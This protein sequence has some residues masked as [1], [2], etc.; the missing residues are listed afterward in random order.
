MIKNPSTK[1]NLWGIGVLFLILLSCQ[2]KSAVLLPQKEIESV[3]IRDHYLVLILLDGSRP[4]EIEAGVAAG[5]LPTFK[6]LFFEEGARFKNVITAFPTVSSPCHQAFISGL[7]PGHHGVPS[8]DWYSRSQ[9]LYTDYLQPHHLRYTNTLF[10]NFRQFLE[11]KIYTDEP[12]LIFRALKGHPSLAVFE[13]ANFGAKYYFPRSIPA[14]PA[15]HSFVAKNHEHWDFAS[16]KYALNLIKKLPTQDLPRFSMINFYGMDFTTHF[17]RAHSTRVADLYIYYDRFLKELYKNFEERGLIKKT[18]F[19][20]ISDHGQHDLEA[21]VDLPKMLRRVGFDTG[22]LDK[23]NSQVV[24]GNHATGTTN[25]YFKT[26][27]DWRQRPS[28]A[29]LKNFPL[30]NKPVDLIKSFLKEPDIEAV[31]TPEGPW[32]T[33]LHFK[34]GHAIIKRRW[35]NNQFLYAYEPD[36]DTDPLDY[37]KNPVIRSWVEKKQFMD[38][39]AWLEQT[40]DK[41]MPD[42][43]VAVPQIF[44]DYRA[45]DMFLI[46]VKEKQFKTDKPSGHG[47]LYKE[48]LRVNFMLHGPDIQAGLY[49]YAR[50]VDAY[51]TFLA[52][53]GL[54]SSHSIDGIL[55]KEVFKSEF[56]NSTKLHQE[57]VGTETGLAMEEFENLLKQKIHQSELEDVE[58]YK[59]EQLLYTLEEFKKDR[60]QYAMP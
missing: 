39:E 29:E 57:R 10:F 41:D 9:D 25:L 38:A 45:G 40:H 13:P 2:Y 11:N 50:S 12:Q 59:L 36:S 43:V 6:K 20:V 44:D 3:P 49:P 53:F 1:I 7:Y 19:V 46:T 14:V 28:Y 51:P 26:N 16:A 34:T 21:A 27:G 17:E 54:K 52:L 4:Q 18:T 30:N 24:W 5:R 47:S 60:A 15:Y 37:L 48:D 33:H 56:F 58:K 31:I 8:L 32:L 55:R 22:H 42:I 35:Q 23:K